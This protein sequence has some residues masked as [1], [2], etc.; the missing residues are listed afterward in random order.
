MDNTSEIVLPDLLANWP[1]K[2][3]PNP[4]QNI[5]ADSAAWT[6]SFGIFS[7]LAYAKAGPDHFRVVCDFM[8]LFFVF[9]EK[10]DAATG[11]QVAQQAANMMNTLR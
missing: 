4:L 3:D 9:D 8:N 6:D 7:S 1:F 2:T 5:V 10:S 11:E